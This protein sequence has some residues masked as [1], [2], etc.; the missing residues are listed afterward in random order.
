[1]K[2]FKT[3]KDFLA[4]RCEMC[5][6]LMLTLLAPVFG[7]CRDVFARP[8]FRGSDGFVRDR[9][10]AAAK[11]AAK[12]APSALRRVL[13]PSRPASAAVRPTQSVLL[14]FFSP[15]H[16]ADPEPGERALSFSAP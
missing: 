6:Q 9:A 3:T 8:V 1:M 14:F 16:G 13:S 15:P 11:T 10:V 7:V 2:D 4:V 12:G 5:V